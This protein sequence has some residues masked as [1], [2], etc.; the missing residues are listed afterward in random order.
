MYFICNICNTRNTD[1]RDIIKKLDIIKRLTIIDK[2]LMQ[3]NKPYIVFI[4]LDNEGWDIKEHYHSSPN[5]IYQTTTKS[6][7]YKDYEDYLKI[8]NLDNDTPVIINDLPRFNEREE[9]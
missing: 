2:K 6:Y 5:N 4:T 3:S 9:G 8:A 1:R 7:F